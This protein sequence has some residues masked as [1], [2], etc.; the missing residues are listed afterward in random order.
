M[1]RPC[2]Q[3]FITSFPTVTDFLPRSGST[4][5]QLPVDLQAD[6]LEALRLADVEGLSQEEGAARMN[7][8][9]ATFG[10]ILERAHAVVADALVH[11][12]PLRIGGG[13]VVASR[14]RHLRCRRCRKG[15]DVPRAAAATFRCPHCRA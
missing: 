2:K 3:R 9:R 4:P 8:S 11:G 7:V 5:V 12:K 15:W 13:E 6:E 10:R 1:A 14:H